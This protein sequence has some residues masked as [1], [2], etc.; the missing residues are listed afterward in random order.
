MRLAT[1]ALTGAMSVIGL[2]VVSDSGVDAS[3]RTKSTVIADAAGQAVAAL[4]QWQQT[5]HPIDYVRFVQHRDQAAAMTER[6]VELADGVLRDAWADVSVAKQHAVLSAVSQLGVPYE[7]LASEPGVGFDCSGLTVWAFGAA[8]V[9]LP[10]VSRDQINEAEATDRD[11]AEAGDLV[12]YPGHV[13]IYL[14]ASTMIHAPN[15][16][17]HVEIA[18]LP[19][20]SLRFGDAEAAQLDDAPADGSLMDRALA[21]TQ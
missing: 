15:S 3:P 21:V 5:S 10:R 6:D 18:G 4:E 8:G 1:I 14:G 20:K 19:D 7:Y 16:G 13:S 2:T 9:E 11:D 12:Y 17:S